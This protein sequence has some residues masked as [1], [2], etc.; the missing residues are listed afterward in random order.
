VSQRADYVSANGT[1][2]KSMVRL[3]QA[4]DEDVPTMWDNTRTYPATARLSTRWWG[5]PYSVG[6]DSDYSVTDAYRRQ[7]RISF[8]NRDYQ[9]GAADHWGD[10][11]WNEHPTQSV[12]SRLYRGDT[13]LKEANRGSL[14]LDD[15]PAEESTYR[16]VHTI[17]R[18]GPIW[19]T[20]SYSESDWTFRSAF[21]S[22][23]G[24]PPKAIPLL[25]LNWSIPTD[26]RNTAR[27]LAPF[28]I[29]LQARHVRGLTG[30]TLKPVTLS[31]S[32]DDGKRWHR[33][34]MVHRPGDRYT[35]LLIHPP[36]SLTTGWV[37]VRAEVSDSIGGTLKQTAIR[38][39]ALR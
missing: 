12:R 13:L 21:E 29:G 23:E 39:Y 24:W 22:D 26:A 19:T 11:Y 16:F 3:P 14:D 2:W 36:K 10:S 9:D 25:D 38:A 30:G 31:V 8:L 1:R 33:V 27:A 6:T 17:T 37:S 20:S 35:G 7:N 18:R 15:L 5:A 4:G 28:T 34:P 32:Y